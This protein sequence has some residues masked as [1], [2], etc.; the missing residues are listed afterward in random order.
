M[1]TLNPLMS[2]TEEDS[3]SNCLPKSELIPPTI[4]CLETYDPLNVSIFEETIATIKILV[5]STIAVD[6]NQGFNL[7][8]KPK[9]PQIP[10]LSKELKRIKL[11]K[12]L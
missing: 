4:S 5:G 3:S 8:I 6:Q 2:K 7:P 1:R 9:V 11:P 10:P 12:T